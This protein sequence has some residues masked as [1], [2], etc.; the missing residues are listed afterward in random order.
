[1]A[2]VE[3]TLWQSVTTH[4]ARLRTG[5]TTGKVRSEAIRTRG[6]ANHSP[7][8]TLYLP[9]SPW[10]PPAAGCL[11]ISTYKQ[12]VSIVICRDGREEV[13]YP[14][15][16]RQRYSNYL[17]QQRQANTYYA[18]PNLQVIKV[19]IEPVKED[20]NS[21]CRR[22]EETCD[23]EP[24]EGQQPL[25]ASTILPT[26]DCLTLDT[27]AGNPSYFSHTCSC[28]LPHPHVHMQAAAE[29]LL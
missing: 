17:Q 15:G 23:L 5:V 29:P 20:N 3:V 10:P 21:P 4:L 22:Q 25:K 26:G 13:V 7:T 19:R 11:Y 2:A 28:P 6:T 8:L 24:W 18:R 14:R 16:T 12:S 1:M 9:T 27:Q